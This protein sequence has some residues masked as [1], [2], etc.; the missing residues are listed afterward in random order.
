MFGKTYNTIGS[1]ESNFIIKTKGDLK[2]Q[3]GNKFIDLIK[4]GKVVPSSKT[5][6]FQEVSSEEDIKNNGIYLIDEDIWVSVGGTKIKLPS[7]SEETTYVSFV[8]EQPKITQ[9]QKYLALSNIGFYYDSLE[10]AKQA[11]LTK[12][13]IYIEK[14]HSLYYINNGVVTKYVGTS[15]N[16]NNKFKELFI[17]SLHIYQDV[18]EI[19]LE[20]D[21]PLVFKVKK[22]PIIRVNDNSVEINQQVNIHGDIIGDTYKLY[23][24]EG[25]SYLEVDNIIANTQQSI[26]KVSEVPLEWVYAENIISAKS[27]EQKQVNCKTFY[28]NQFKTGDSIYILMENSAKLTYSNSTYQLSYPVPVD[29]VLKVGTQFITIPKNT[30]I[31]TTEQGSEN[32]EV[33]QGQEYLNLDSYKNKLGLWKFTV[34]EC[35][36]NEFTITLPEEDSSFIRRCQSV[37]ICSANKPLLTIN[38]EIKYSEKGKV[39][40]IIGDISNVKINSIQKES[41][42]YGIFSENLLS[43]NG[44]LFDV[45]FKKLQEYPKYSQD[46]EIPKD[47]TNEQYDLV[48]PNLKWVKSLLDNLTPK[49]SIMMFSNSSIPENWAICD[50]NNGTPNLINNFVKSE[51]RSNKND[52][53]VKDVAYSLIFIMKIK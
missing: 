4:N 51:Q 22:L 33:I 37:A 29:V 30:T 21:Y 7:N 20:S 3:W 35:T 48:V 18:A 10:S 34:S 27:S 50:G 31:I 2:I 49:G 47:I 43:T 9:D 26:N 32:Y 41:L 53:I 16:I 52:Y 8:Q 39:R 40:T 5:E 13:I 36:P 28:K 42:N 45:T 1:S 19:L 17:E 24:V 15:D 11:N 38:N 25:Q 23:S 44:Q 12:G 6:L 14:E 46:M